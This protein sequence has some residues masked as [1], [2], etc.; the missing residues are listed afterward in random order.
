M[1]ERIAKVTKMQEMIVKVKHR[2]AKGQNAKED[3]QR[4]KY[5]IRQPKDIMDEMQKRAAKGE[6]AKEDRQMTK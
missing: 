5:K 2:R 4:T 6:N 3:I 1:Q